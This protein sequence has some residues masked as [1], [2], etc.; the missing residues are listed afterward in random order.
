MKANI[1]TIKKV[2]KNTDLIRPDEY[3]S[4]VQIYKLNLFK[5]IKSYDTLKR[6][7]K[8]DI[9]ENKNKNFQAIRYGKGKGR[10]YLISGESIL[11]VIKQVESGSYIENGKNQ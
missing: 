8:R 7:V 10:R 3:Y 2:T 11:K 9:E 6:W 4:L 5:W 1:E